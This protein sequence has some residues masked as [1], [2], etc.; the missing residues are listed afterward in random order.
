MRVRIPV[1]MI[2]RLEADG[3]YIRVHAGRRTRLPRARL[4][5]LEERLNPELFA[6]I[7]R[8]AIVRH[9][10]V[11]A[12]RRHESGRAFAVLSDGREAP[13]SKRCFARIAAALRLRSR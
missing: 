5:D 2:E 8:S 7:Q 4:S 13:I 12:I 9:D 3:D 11:T 6:R 10:L 1:E